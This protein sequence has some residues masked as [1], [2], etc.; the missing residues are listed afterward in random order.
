MKYAFATGACI[1][2]RAFLGYETKV[3]ALRCG[4]CG[5]PQTNLPSGGYIK[6]AHCDTVSAVD[7]KPAASNASIAACVAPEIYL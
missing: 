7:R 4:H 3:K 2:P 6:C 5:S 1:I